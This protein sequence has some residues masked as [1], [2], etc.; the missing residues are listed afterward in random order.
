MNVTGTC[1]G[2]NSKMTPEISNSCII[3]SPWVSDEIDT[4]LIRVSYMT[5]VK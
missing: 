2:K 1:S 5:K 4:H 3:T